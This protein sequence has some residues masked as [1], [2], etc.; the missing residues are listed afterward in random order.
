LSKIP[1]AK[2]F[3]YESSGEAIYAISFSGLGYIFGNQWTNISGI[4][5]YSSAIIA[6]II[7]IAIIWHFIKN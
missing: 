2:F 4:F 7:L 6:L 3:L 1:F 5:E